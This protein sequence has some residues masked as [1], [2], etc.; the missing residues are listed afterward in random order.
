MI[1]LSDVKLLKN[2]WDIIG[3]RKIIEKHALRSPENPLSLVEI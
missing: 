3:T 2:L 1:K